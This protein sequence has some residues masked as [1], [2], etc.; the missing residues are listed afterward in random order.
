MRF[1]LALLI[2]VAFWKGT[3]GVGQFFLQYFGNFN[4]ELRYYGILQTCR[5]RFLGILDGI[6]NSRSSPP[7]FSEPFR[8]SDRFISC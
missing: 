8:V 3:L 7:T 5:M 2:A 6:K 4:L 1:E